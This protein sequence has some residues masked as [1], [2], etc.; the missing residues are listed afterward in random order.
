MNTCSMQLWWSFTEVT[1]VLIFGRLSLGWLSLGF[2]FAFYLK[3]VLG[4][5][6]DP[7]VQDFHD[8]P[9][10]IDT[11]SRHG[12]RRVQVRAERRRDRHISHG[13]R[14]HCAAG[15][16]LVRIKAEQ[17]CTLLHDPE[18]QPGRFLITGDR[19]VPVAGL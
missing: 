7:R 8:P 16:S 17:L 19:P 14:L 5:W 3:I 4:G 18:H 12:H 9:L 1:L 15:A 13:G 10:I 11:T 6:A 2:S